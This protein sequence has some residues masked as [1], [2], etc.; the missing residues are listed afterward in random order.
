[1]TYLFG[2]FFYQSN[3]KFKNVILESMQTDN[4]IINEQDESQQHQL[5][6][7]MTEIEETIVPQVED[8]PIIVQSIPTVRTIAPKPAVSKLIGTLLYLILLIT[9]QNNCYCSTVILI[10]QVVHLAS[11]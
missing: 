5:Q 4:M 9:Y 1:M 2:R 10:Q 3:T 6:Q 8:K 11:K 7:Q